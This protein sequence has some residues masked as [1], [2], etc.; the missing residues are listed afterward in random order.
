M[1]RPGPH[2]NEEKKT[3]MM[4]Q[5]FLHQSQYM[6]LYCDFDPAAPPLSAI[7]VRWNVWSTYHFPVVPRGSN[8][9]E[10]P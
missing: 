1:G 7:G 9:Y 4:D 2:Q 8:R 5:K 10:A 6:N 3:Y